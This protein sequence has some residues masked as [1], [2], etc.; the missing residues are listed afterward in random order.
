MTDQVA[1]S[2]RGGKRKRQRVGS[3]G[4]RRQRQCHHTC[5][6][7]TRPGPAIRMTARLSSHVSCSS[8]VPPVLRQRRSAAV[9]PLR[10]VWPAANMTDRDDE[11]AIIARSAEERRFVTLH[12]SRAPSTVAAGTL[13]RARRRGQPFV[14]RLRSVNSPHPG[15]QPPQRQADALPFY[16]SLHETL[17]PVICQQFCIE[18]CTR[19][20]P[21]SLMPPKR[22]A[23][24]PAEPPPALPPI[25]EGC[26][27]GLLGVGNTGMAAAWCWNW[28]ETVLRLHP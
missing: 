12:H 8:P 21:A 20:P 7:C 11:P 24:G 9:R 6:K 18:K 1:L 17:R 19:G 3:A 5:R 27:R 22:K 28:K 10:A 25:F 15:W 23:A 13:L 2:K 16:A 26:R 4:G 14:S